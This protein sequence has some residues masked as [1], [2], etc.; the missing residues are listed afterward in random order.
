MFFRFSHAVQST[1]VEGDAEQMVALINV[2]KIVAMNHCREYVI[3]PSYY[4]E[5]PPVSW[6]VWIEGKKDP[7]ELTESEGDQL[8]ALLERAGK[9]IL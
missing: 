1:V 7:Y 9:V 4:P 5:K 3:D 2:E 8:V 6:R